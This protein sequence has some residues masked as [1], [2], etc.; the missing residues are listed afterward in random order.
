[1]VP[2]HPPSSP[3]LVTVYKP[4]E[5][6]PLPGPGGG[7]GAPWDPAGWQ[8]VGERLTGRCWPGASDSL[9]GEED[10][11]EGL[12]VRGRTTLEPSGPGRPFGPTQSPRPKLGPCTEAPARPATVH[13]VGLPARDRTQQLELQLPPS[14]EALRLLMPGI[15]DGQRRS[16][17]TPRD[18]IL[19]S[20][21]SGGKHPA[22]SITLRPGK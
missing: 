9:Q 3:E 21:V 10:P 15:I 13:A 6:R 2:A 4:A 19:N 18:G 14:Q 16:P 7:M 22:D 12:S 20:E 8:G 5:P 17:P 1:M 11:Q